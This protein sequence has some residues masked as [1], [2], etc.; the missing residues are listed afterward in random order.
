[1]MKISVWDGGLTENHLR[2]VTQLGVDYLDF[3]D[4]N[5][6][7]GVKEKGYPDI[8]ALIKIKKHIRSWGLD[9]NRV[10]LPNITEKFMK[11]LPGGDEEFDNTCKALKIFG[12]AGINLVRQRFAGDTFN[13]LMTSYRSR[14]RGGYTSRGE[15]KFLTKDVPQTP[16]YKELEEWWSRFC[17]VYRSLVPIAEEYDIKLAIHPSDTPNP[18]TPFGGL[19]FH[20]V[21]DEFPSKNVGYLYCIGTRAEAGGSSLVLD[22]INNYGRK[23]KIFL[24]HF[25]NVRGSLATADGFEE[26][27]L[28]DGDMNM[29]KILLEL[30]KIGYDGC[31]NPD[32]IPVLEGN[33]G[34]AYSVGYIKAMLAALAGI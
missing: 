1:M 26:I 21:I 17:Y 31:L 22:E 10:T 25:R 20:R 4:C 2:Q 7:P 23:G 12:E 15:S 28:D 27:L 11:D 16:N 19:G 24:V 32:H 8:D 30:H 14:H 33:V 5:S 3:G 29:F 6:F 13:S 9:I 34:L 18:D